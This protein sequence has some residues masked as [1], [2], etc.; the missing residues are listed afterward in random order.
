MF[1]GGGVSRYIK[2]NYM[3][4]EQYNSIRALR[5]SWW[6][7]VVAIL[8]ALLSPVINLHIS[9]EWGKR[10]RV[11]TKIDSLERQHIFNPECTVEQF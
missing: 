10:E 6:S 11:E 7:L 9:E 3:T 4:E 1:V 2:R 8:I 5:I